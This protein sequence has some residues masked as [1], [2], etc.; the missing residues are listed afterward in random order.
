MELLAEAPA[1]YLGSDP[2]IES[3]SPSVVALAASL[4]ESHPGDIDFAH[5]SFEWV[6]DNVS[7]SFDAQDRRVTITAT[8]VLR[9]RVGLCYAKA[10]L[11]TAMLRAE[12]VPAGL[13]YQRL[14]DDAI[15]QGHVVHGLIALHLEGA[16][17]RQ[18]PRGNKSGVNAQF[19][20]GAEQLAWVADPHLGEIDYPVVYDSP[21]AS[22][23]NALRS[24]DDILELYRS[25]LPDALTDAEAGARR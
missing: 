6:R 25:G 10:H 19:S 13:C 12:G 8:E 3:C 9:E 22:V 18:D 14:A 24:T 7:H 4:R 16:W 21:V 23:V 1:S 17:H 20:L 15:G 11:L 2:F 5:A